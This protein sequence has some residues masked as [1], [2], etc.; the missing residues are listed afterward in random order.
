[1][2]LWF[3]LSIGLLQLSAGFGD[4]PNLMIFDTYLLI[5]CIIFPFP[6]LFKELTHL[7]PKLEVR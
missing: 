3:A 6:C 5:L 2:L 4:A 1:M 7:K